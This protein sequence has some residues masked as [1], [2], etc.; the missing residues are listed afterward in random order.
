VITVRNSLWALLALFS[1]LAASDTDIVITEIN[2]HPLGGDWRGEF[3]ELYNRGGDRVDMAGWFLESGISFVFPAGT[4]L[5]P[6][7]FLVVC[8][9]PDFIAT[10]YGIANVA[11]P[12]SGELADCGGRITLRRA[13]GMFA[14]SALYGWYAENCGEDG[15]GD[16]SPRQ[17]ESHVSGAAWSRLADGNG[18][19]MERADPSQDPDLPFAWHAS[20]VVGGTPGRRNGGAAPENPPVRINEI[21][22]APGN[23]WVEFSNQSGAPLDI[24]GYW[25][26]RGTN[27]SVRQ[28]L[29]AGA[30][31]DFRVV[32][33]SSAAAGGE[34]R[35]L[36]L[37]PDGE[38]IVD[39]LASRAFSPSMSCGR[40]P[41]G[42][43][44]TYV[45]PEPTQGDPNESPVTPDIYLSEIMYRPQVEPSRL[46]YV[47]IADRGAAAVD[48]G[49]WSF[50]FE[51]SLAY[52]FPQDAIL[53]PGEEWVICGDP[54]AIQTHYG[55]AG[56][57]GPW[58]GVLPDAV[59]TVALR[60]ALGNLVDRIT[61]GSD[62]VWP[63]AANGQGSSLSLKTRNPAIDPSYGQAWEAVS[64]GNPG[65]PPSERAIPPIVAEVS[66]DP[67]IPRSTETVHITCRINDSDSITAANLRYTIDGGGGTSTVPLYDDGLH[68]DGGAGDSWWGATIGPFA[69]GKIIAFHIL[70]TDQ[71]SSTTDAPGTSKDFLFLVSNGTPPANDSADYRVIVTAATWT[72]LTTRPVESNDLLDA[73]FIGD[74]GE[75]FYNVGLRY[76]DTGARSATLKSYRVQ[77]EQADRFHGIR[78]LELSRATTNRQF[79]CNDFMERAGV[80]AP[81]AWMV[82][83]WVHGAWDN[84]Y[85]RLEVADRDFVA[86]VFGP[87][88]DAGTLYRGQTATSPSG[89]ADL[90]YRGADPSQ[91]RPF[92]ANLTGDGAADTY[93]A[94]IRLCAA[95]SPAQTPD[96]AFPAAVEEVIDADEWLLYFAAQACI[97][98]SS[99]TISTTTGDDYF[100]YFRSSD[101][102]AVLI[103]GVLDETFTSGSEALFRPTVASIRRFLTNP[104][105]CQRY[106]GYLAKLLW[107]P[108]ARVEMKQTMALLDVIYDFGT[109]DGDDTFLANRVGFLYEH[110]PLKVTGGV[111]STDAPAATFIPDGATWRYFEG[112]SNPTGGDTSWTTIGFNDAAW[113]Q[114][115]A[116]FGYGG[117]GETTLLSTMQGQYTTLFIRRSFAVDSPAAVTAL[118]MT[119]TYDEG[120]VAYLNG[121]EVR[122]SLVTN[123]NG[124]DPVYT[125][126]ADDPGL[127]EP[128]TETVDLKNR[129]NLLVEGTNVLAIVGLNRSLTSSD[130]FITASLS[131][132][133]GGATAGGGC[134]ERAYVVAEGVV[135]SGF[136]PAPSTRSVE[137][138]GEEA[139]FD[140]LYATWEAAVS[141][142][143]GENVIPVRALGDG[144][145]VV[146]ENTFVITRVASMTP[147]TG[148]IGSDR[149]LTA[150]GGPYLLT[151]TLTVPAGRLLS[152]AAGTVVIAEANASILVE[153]R[154]E[155]L[156]TEAAPIRF[157]GSRC[158]SSLWQG[159]GIRDTGIGAGDPVHRLRYCH[160]RW[161]TERS[162]FT[163]HISPHNARL[164]MENCE[165]R[166]M[167]SDGIDAE[168]AE[169]EVRDCFIEETLE[170][171]HTVSTT[172]L[173]TGTTFH[174]MIGD[175]DCIDFDLDGQR[176]S[177]IE[178]CHFDGSMDDC[179]DL[180][181]K[182]CAVINNH[183]SNIWDKGISSEPM[184]AGAPGTQEFRGNVIVHCG[185]AIALKSGAVCDDGSHN[186]IV[187]NV[188]GLDVYAKTPGAAHSEG[189]FPFCISW[190]NKVN[191]F[192]DDVSG[193]YLLITDSDIGG[194]SV[195]PGAG[196]INE[197]PLFVDEYADNFY[198]RPSSPCILDGGNYMGALPACTPGFIR[199]DTNSDGRVDVSDAVFSLMCLFGGATALCEDANDVNDQGDLT[200]ADPIY[201][202]GYLFAGT[203]EP[204]APFPDPGS[205]GT[206]EDS[207]SCGTFPMCQ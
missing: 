131:S 99:A 122:R 112:R 24:G 204:P 189:T 48:V 195:W 147:L 75:I 18:A 7:A 29:P 176:Q 106:Y 22:R 1:P 166:N 43:D 164:V 42:G 146:G 196:N 31:E 93:E 182:N 158:G 150:A 17:P 87:A 108:F 171:V 115:Q 21:G 184:N 72:L 44:E 202:L 143:P 56:V 51:G 83:L 197:D 74:R 201:L 4:A 89:S 156:G 162:D 128:G 35:Y 148:T 49:G 38:T 45:F 116:P 103:P 124:A 107:G 26:A 178:N 100:V 207:L 6:E 161:G 141:L 9:A 82:N 149:T 67:P 3:V 198:L 39:V 52:V 200:I 36:L 70:A 160:F 174:Q 63:A 95:F 20:A 28:A 96:L 117:R 175:K 73:T 102:K 71:A 133:G 30:F 145:A 10:T 11:G 59:G 41:D 136:A 84:K 187:G 65:T 186:T 173:I 47:A 2:Y 203:A 58:V 134:G 205:D 125:S 152:I 111:S 23:G 183:I 153:G 113:P 185:T 25:L 172:S 190:H 120:Y 114:A 98:N 127:G 61:Y 179:L 119:V 137:V 16:K 14:S 33:L 94:V 192:A 90:S 154:I 62:G 129:V 60:D 77:F 180:G 8:A 86:R 19:T 85:L 165:V 151:G 194:D 97:S 79:Q 64:N 157:I 142:S 69:D 163:G 118:S 76:G 46:E 34:E 170:G 88:D 57:L 68:D 126:V 12:W 169:L 15:G 132:G 81:Q 37:A 159:I 53:D 104:A 50:E 91:Y 144:D 78:S 109:R 191:V 130:F 101:G 105:F 40:F 177:R 32:S 123:L 54:A 206:P 92:Y 140:P 188:T 193:P 168:D 199:G 167:R 139:V 121:T 13:D 55:I 27:L 135:L 80:P 181:G 66:H 5:E 138:A 110:V 155:A